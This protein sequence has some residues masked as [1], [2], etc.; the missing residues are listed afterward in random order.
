M[1]RMEENIAEP[2]GLSPAV[3][4]FLMVGGVYQLALGL[5]ARWF[6]ESFG[7]WLSDGTGIAVATIRSYGLYLLILGLAALISARWPVKARWI[8]LL[9]IVSLVV[10]AAW[11]YFV[12]VD[13]TINK[14]F[15]FHLIM[16]TLLWVVLLGYANFRIFEF[17]NREMGSTP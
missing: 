17:N 14:K 11:Q 10:S 1:E 12:L 5:L 15:L 8:L 4:G 9:L 2:A 7:L 6:P 3:I 16:N 13:Q